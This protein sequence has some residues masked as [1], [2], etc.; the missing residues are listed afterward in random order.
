VYRHN[1]HRARLT[2]SE[3]RGNGATQEV[4]HAGAQT[5][6][7]AAHD[8]HF[9]IEDRGKMAESVRDVAGQLTKLNAYAFLVGY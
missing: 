5:A 2:V 6:A 8:D 3:V 7:S 9:G 4:M 1:H